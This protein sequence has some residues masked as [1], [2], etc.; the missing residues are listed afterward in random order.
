[1]RGND[2]LFRCTCRT[3][4]TLLPWQ[5]ISSFEVDRKT[6]AKCVFRFTSFAALRRLLRKDFDADAVRSLAIVGLR[7]TM[8]PNLSRARGRV[9]LTE[10]QLPDTR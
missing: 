4:R 10:L 1:L 7:R 3:S 5:F 2:R 9:L 6:G 8:M